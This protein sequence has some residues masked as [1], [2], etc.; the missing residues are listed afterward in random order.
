MYLA[1]R[2]H[3]FRKH[4]PVECKVMMTDKREPWALLEIDTPKH[5]HGSFLIASDDP[6]FWD[7]LASAAQDAASKMRAELA[8][9]ASIG[10]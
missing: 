6:D 4:Q 10:A 9:A 3:A 8:R 7:R 5:A 1:T 2:L